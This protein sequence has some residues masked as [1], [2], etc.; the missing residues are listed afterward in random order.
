MRKVLGPVLA[1][2]AACATLSASFQPWYDGR[3]GSRVRAQ[4]LVNGVTGMDADLLASLF[5]PLAFAAFVGLIAAVRRSR[6]LMTFAGMPVLATV[7]L[8]LA[9]EADTARGLEARLAGPGLVLAVGAGFLFLAA[10]AVSGPPPLSCRRYRCPAQGRERGAAGVGGGVPGVPPGT[11][12]GSVP[13]TPAG[14]GPG[15]RPGTAREGP[16]GGVRGR[17]TAS[18]APE[19]AA[20]DGGRGRGGTRNG[21]GTDDTPPREPHPVRH[22]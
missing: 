11:R 14:A 8:S 10:A 2:A 12:P 9:R 21:T 1:L 5:L 17:G 15:M 7:S 13:G 4:D 18:G 6:V 22:E 16:S 3:E 19:A 20:P